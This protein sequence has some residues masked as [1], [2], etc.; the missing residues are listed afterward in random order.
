[1]KRQ[2]F[3][4]KFLPIILVLTHLTISAAFFLLGPFEWPISNSETLT[5]FITAACLS[6]G[7]GYVLGA[8]KE[9]RATSF[10]YLRQIYVIGAVTSCVMLFPSAYVYTGKMPWNVFS[11]IAD[12]GL[13]YNEF[14]QRLKDT[15]GSRGIVITARVLTQWLIYPIIPLAVLTWHELKF[16]ERLLLPA[17]VCSAL[18]FSLLRGTDQGTFD[19]AFLFAASMLIAAIRYLQSNRKKLSAYLVSPISIAFAGVALIIVA[20]LFNTFVTRKAER[21]GGNIGNI[22][23]GV[24]KICADPNH[25]ASQSFDTKGRF[26]IAM[27]TAYISQGY[28]GLSLAL[29]SDF[30]STLG[31]GHS[32]PLVRVYEAITGDKAL[33]EHSYTYRL[34]DHNWSDEHHWSTLY[35]WLAND[36]GFPGAILIVAAFAYLLASSWRDATAGKNNAAAISCCMLL[37]TFFYLPANNQLFIGAD[38]YVAFIVWLIIWLKNRHWIDLAK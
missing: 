29:N 32:P 11:A 3:E 21:F 20:A 15:S 17:T 22:C 28:Y 4:Y 36:V 12:Q 1:M 26:A 34:R 37:Q 2:S 16:W 38:T 8:R 19:L 9:P 10:P 35:V 33:Y 18:I 27:V 13:A 6:I 31:F 30:N 23:I 25:A 7:C 5:T 24:T 14:Q